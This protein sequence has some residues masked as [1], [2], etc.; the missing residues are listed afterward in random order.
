MLKPRHPD[1]PGDVCKE[2]FNAKSEVLVSRIKR[3]ALLF[4]LGLVL[5]GA[6]AIPLQSELDWLDQVTGASLSVKNQAL[7]PAPAWAAWLTKVRL[8][9]RETGVSNPFLFYGTDWLAFGHFV[10]AIA[11]IGVLRDPVRNS[12][13]FTFGIIACVLVVPYALIFGSIRGIPL[14]WRVIDCSFGIFG[15]FPLVLCKRWLRELEART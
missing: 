10:I 6:T 11:F 7:H 2:H 9:L 4:I 15:L 8:A 13:L 5:S 12:W 1:E 3:W 14:W